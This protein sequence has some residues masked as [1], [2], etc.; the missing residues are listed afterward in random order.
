MLV[1][2]DVDAAAFAWVEFHLPGVFPFPER[3]MVLLKYGLVVL[4]FDS[5]VQKAV[6]CKESS[7]GVL[8]CIGYVIDICQEKKRYS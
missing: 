2:H 3:V 7:T 1:E 5:S 8:D 6:V 4:V